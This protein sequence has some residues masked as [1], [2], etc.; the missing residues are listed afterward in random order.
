MPYADLQKRRDNVRRWKKAN[1]D[2][3]RA[4][5]QR[6]RTRRAL[7]PQPSPSPPPQPQR[8]YNLRSRQVKRPEKIQLVNLV[9]V[10]K[11]YR[12][13]DTLQ[14]RLKEKEYRQR[15]REKILVQKREYRQRNREKIRTQKE[16]YYERN[17]E[18]ILVQKREYRQRNREKI[19]TQRKEYR[20][21]NQRVK[22][23]KRNADRRYRSINRERRN[24]RN[25]EYYH[26]NRDRILTQRNQRVKETKRNAD[27]RYRA[28]N[29]ERRNQQNREYYRRNRDCLLT[30]AKARKR[31]KRDEIR[32]KERVL[33]EKTNCDCG[34]CLVCGG[35][36][37][38][39]WS[40]K[41]DYLLERPEDLE[42]LDRRCRSES[43]TSSLVDPQLVEELER[44]LNEPSEC[45][46]LSDEEDE[47]EERLIA[48]RTH[49]EQGIQRRLDRWE[50]EREL[51]ESIQYLAG[52]LGA[53][54]EQ[55]IDMERAFAQFRREDAV[56]QVPEFEYLHTV[57]ITSDLMSQLEQNLLY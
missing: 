13:K 43:D 21:R 41:F 36:S 47:L 23:T 16:E 17:R 46:D 11:D 52:D 56:T 33:E 26:R 15:N 9:V 54:N 14:C 45:S 51:E 32:E 10:L 35:F 37:T 30:R 5:K 57:T 2:K 34:L 31:R 27:R 4:Q 1:P 40:S 20:Q 49:H 39:S 8:R 3:V 22:E 55:L 7:S 48:L 25:R 50:E 28:D 12:K 44:M 24:Q 38:T 18:R 42:D 6:Y 29:R 19:R 53:V